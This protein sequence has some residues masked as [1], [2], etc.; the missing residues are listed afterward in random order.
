MLVPISY[1]I[2]YESRSLSRGETWR[3]SFQD[4]TDNLILSNKNKHS[5]SKQQSNSVFIIL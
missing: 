4:L 5:E 3:A 2:F 1:V